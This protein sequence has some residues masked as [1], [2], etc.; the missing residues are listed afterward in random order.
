MRHR[1]LEVFPVMCRVDDGCATVVLLL[2]PPGVYQA[3]SDTF[4]LIDVLREGGYATGR[5][6][7]DI[8]SGTG[9]LALAAAQAGYL[10]STDIGNLYK[11]E[12]CF[13]LGVS[14]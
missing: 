7:L 13:L 5:R 2:W 11:T 1:K 4:L 3:D 6:V 8:G 10:F 12:M 9:A 14:P